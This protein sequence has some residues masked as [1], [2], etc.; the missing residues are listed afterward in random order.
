MKDDDLKEYYNTQLQEGLEYQDF[1]Q[2]VFAEFG[3]ILQMYSSRLYQ[4]QIGETRSGYE[5]KY[6]KQFKKTGNLFIECC[7]RKM[8]QMGPWVPSGI[9]RNDNTWLYTIGD[10]DDIFIIAKRDLLAL[11]DGR[12]EN[13]SNG[14]EMAKGFLL[15]GSRHEPDEVSLMHFRPKFDN[16]LIDLKKKHGTEA[17]RLRQEIK[18]GLAGQFSLFAR[19]KIF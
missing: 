9:H 4:E 2:D 3:L 18:D 11:D 16:Y 12:H 17:K 5:I 1:V 19:K 14:V 10:Y 15:L 7:E 8:R 13:L 6:D